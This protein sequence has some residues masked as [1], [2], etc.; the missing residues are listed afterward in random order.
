MGRDVD[1]NRPPRRA[2]PSWPLSRRSSG[3]S[4]AAR[5]LAEAPIDQDKVEEYARLQ[6]STYEDADYLRK[7][8][9]GASAV[10]LVEQETAVGKLDSDAS[11]LSARSPTWKDPM[12]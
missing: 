4:S 7:V 11:S 9:M 12:S 2:P 1:G 5:R 3:G 10:E 8:L 6:Q